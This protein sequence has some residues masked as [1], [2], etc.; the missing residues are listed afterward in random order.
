MKIT[1]SVCEQRAISA[2]ANTHNMNVIFK[3]LLNLF[4]VYLSNV[5]TECPPY[6]ELYQDKACFHY[7]ITPGITRNKAD[8]ECEK[9]YHGTLASLDDE[10]QERWVI[11][12]F[13]GL[14]KNLTTSAAWIGLK[15]AVTASRHVVHLWD[16]GSF[17]N[18]T[19][20]APNQPSPDGRECVYVSANYDTKNNS[21]RSS[22]SD[23]VCQSQNVKGFICRL[24]YLP[25][26]R[27]VTCLSE[28]ERKEL[29]NCWRDKSVLAVA[30]A[31]LCCLI[32]ILL[33]I[34]IRY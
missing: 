12:K 2:G 11:R 13:M 22:W 18:Y 10:S 24:P 8:N 6:Y 1:F 34:L 25:E 31:C 15:R 30:I 33:A 20:W 5:L 29:G 7:G 16:D 17:S 3:I 32:L 28:S 27:N 14:S 26:L 21:F 9:Y 4:L 23:N 19:H